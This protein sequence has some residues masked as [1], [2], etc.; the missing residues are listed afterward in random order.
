MSRAGLPLLANEFARV[1]VQLAPGAS[2]TV[3]IAAAL[4]ADATAAGHVCVDLAAVA[5]RAAFDG[6]A[7]VPPLAAVLEALRATPLVAAPGEFAPLVLD[8]T[9]LYL[10][11]YWH[12]E[13]ALAT[14]LAARAAHAPDEVDETALARTL[15]R[16]FPD[17]GAGANL[18]KV[19]AAVACMRRLV[20]ISGGPGTG[21]TSTVARV[22]A[23]LVTLAGDARLAIGLAAPTGKAAARLEASLAHHA[24]TAS[25]GLHA[26]TLHR[27]LGLA[28]GSTPRFDAQNPLP[29]DVVVVDEASMMDLAAAAKLVA[30][31]PAHAR[32]ILLGDKDQLASVEA[33]A[34]LASIA[35][36][37]SGFS[38]PMRRAL[39]RVTGAALPAAVDGGAPRNAPLSDAIV[40]LDRSYR[41]DAARGVGRLAR[42]VRAGDVDAAL[43]TLDEGVEARIALPDAEALGGAA[44]AGYRS[45]FDTVRAT[46]D[47]AACFAALAQFRVLAAVRGGPLG[48]EAL[49]A[50]VERRLAAEQAAV[51]H[52]RWYP[53]RPVMVTRNDYALRLSNGDVGIVLPVPGASGGVSVC[54]EAPDGSTRRL[55]PARMPDCE[56]VYAM[57]V[58]KSQGSEFDEVLLVLP[59]EPSQVLSRELLYTGVTRARTRVTVHARRET[60]AAAIGERV[61]R[62][63]GLA[64]RLWGP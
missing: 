11:R 17:E 24:D 50:M 13:T 51:L 40:L 42:A 62:D 61:V 27:L 46:A 58:H 38:P 43:A 26:V 9:R 23:A 54:F 59:D 16:L 34:V 8:G 37:A 6:A 63:S 2:E 31:L 39:E 4:V 1:V 41:F 21:K 12:Y 60:V 44:F 36:G 52:R 55:S 48:V 53:G 7:A 10:H 18:Q 49:N 32:L 57:T 15:A 20:V 33:G 22:L 19:A 28:A 5:G 35:S 56:T 45:Y 25:L 64:E 3:R 14:S 47:P 29:L 30:A